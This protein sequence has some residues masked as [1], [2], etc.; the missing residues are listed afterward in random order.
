MT[1]IMLAIGIV[2]TIGHVVLDLWNF[3]QHVMHARDW[4]TLISAVCLVGHVVFTGE[5]QEWIVTLT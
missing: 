2:F 5:L 4:L 1:E 3:K